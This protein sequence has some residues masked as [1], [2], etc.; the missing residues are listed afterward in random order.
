[1]KTGLPAF[2]CLLSRGWLQNIRVGNYFVLLILF[3]ACNS[4]LSLAEE[5][6]SLSLPVDIKANTKNQ[7]SE[8]SKHVNRIKDLKLTIQIR[9]ILSEDA[10]LSQLNI[11]VSV[12]DGILRLWGPVPDSL[13]MEK[14]LKKVANVKLIFDIKNEMYIGVLEDIPEPLFI[15]E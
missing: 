6:P 11:G 2:I 13:K 4:Q 5:G 10:E 8:L 3:W 1:L 7:D 14:S 15:K 9:K 12:K